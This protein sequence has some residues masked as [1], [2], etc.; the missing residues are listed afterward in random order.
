MDR[1]KQF[2][3]SWKTVGVNSK[4][5]WQHSNTHDRFNSFLLKRLIQKLGSEAMP[6]I[7]EA[8][9]A[10]GLEDGRKMCENLQLDTSTGKACLTPLETIAL[11]SGIDSEISAESR[12]KHSAT[13]K[14]KSCPFSTIFHD[15]SPEIRDKACES[16]ATGLTRAVNSSAD[17]KI[18]KGCC[19]NHKYCEFMVSVR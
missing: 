6:I 9:I 15:M 1:F 13:L 4:V 10:I 19:H 11:L 18:N 2:A 3:N 7:A 17:L 16:Y 5:R 8:G 14:V 12:N